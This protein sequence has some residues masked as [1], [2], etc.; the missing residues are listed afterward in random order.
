MPEC[1]A[2]CRRHFLEVIGAQGCID[3]VDVTP[4][5]AVLIEIGNA[6]QGCFD[7]LMN[8]REFLQPLLLFDGWI[9]AGLEQRENIPGDVRIF[10]ERF[11]DMFLRM[12]DSV[13]R[14]YRA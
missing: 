11:G 4:E 5:G 2:A 13:W 3:G 6:A 14:R 9:E 8:F 12:N 7:C 1:H 10:I